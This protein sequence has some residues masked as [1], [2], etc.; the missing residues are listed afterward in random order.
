VALRG[1]GIMVVR[2][3]SPIRS[4][5]NLSTTYERAGQGY[6]CFFSFLLLLVF[7]YL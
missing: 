5:H 6:C 1:M 3:S 4:S 2:P 7:G